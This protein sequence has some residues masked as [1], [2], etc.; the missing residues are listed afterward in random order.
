MRDKKIVID[1]L[2]GQ[3]YEIMET[4]FR[5]MAN[6]GLLIEKIKFGLSFY[7]RIEPKDIHFAIGIYPKPK[8]YEK[9][10][11]EVV[12]AYII[13]QEEK[14]WKHLFSKEYFH[15]FMNENG[16]ALE[17]IDR[18][19]QIENIKATLKL[20][21]IS[22][23]ILSLL[24]I[25][26]MT[27]IPMGINLYNFNSNIGLVGFFILPMVMA[28]M[29]LHLIY[30]IIRYF[31]IK[32]KKN[33]GEVQIKN[34]AGLVLFKKILL[35]LTLA[36]IGI[37]VVALIADSFISGNKIFLFFLPMT[38]G[39]FVAFKLRGFFTGRNLGAV[40]KTIIALLVVFF[41]ITIASA[42]GLSSIDDG[43]GKELPKKF[44]ALKLEDIGIEREA[45]VVIFRK[46]G[47]VLM[48]LKYNYTEH[49][50]FGWDS[51]KYISTQA[52]KALN[53]DLADYIFDLEL[54]NSLRYYENLLSAKEYYSDYDKAVFLEHSERG[55]KE[56]FL[57]R[58]EYIF[59]FSG[60]FDL[61]EESSIELINQTVDKIIS[62]L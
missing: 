62:G 31:R 26:N 56:V 24:M 61:Q 42:M 52:E 49:G 37:F 10:S 45:D 51:S 40:A 50:N 13:A 54:E 4:R 25:Y 57:Q 41:V 5:N 36:F 38:I 29:A 32:R 59:S 17:E 6:K 19:D 9:P 46:E 8:S 3:D 14:G 23:T 33:I 7:K 1:G 16:E 55:I 53:K 34:I 35:I 2:S 18:T 39:I 20:E 27:R 58:G 28:V 15:V 22:F 21:I 60:D 12:L 48:P 44:T 11:E 47:S 43:F 30:D